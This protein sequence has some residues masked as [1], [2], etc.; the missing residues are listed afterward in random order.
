LLVV[1]FHVFAVRDV[2][3]E[4]SQSDSSLFQADFTASSGQENRLVACGL[5]A[6]VLDVL[7][8]GATGDTLLLLNRHTLAADAVHDTERGA[9]IRMPCFFQFV[10]L[11][12]EMAISSSS[13]LAVGFFAD[14]RR[15]LRSS[16]FS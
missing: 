5:G 11:F 15:L 8:Q 9:Q 10:D 13:V 12:S 1:V 14:E 16:S 4:R 2:L 3:F 6:F 7:A